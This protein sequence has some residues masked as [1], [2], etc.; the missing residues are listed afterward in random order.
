[1]GRWVVA[2]N[3]VVGFLLACCCWARYPSVLLSL[4][5][6]YGM[7]PKLLTRFALYSVLTCDMTPTTALARMLRVT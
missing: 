1:M 4:T 5:I 6:V 3:E 7:V 2:G